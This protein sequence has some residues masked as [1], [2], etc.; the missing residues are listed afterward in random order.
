GNC[1]HTAAG[2]A[3]VLEVLPA[4]IDAARDAGLR[5]VTL[6]AALSSN[7]LATECRSA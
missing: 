7:Q 6:A 5:F 2:V 3:V 4:V 1:A